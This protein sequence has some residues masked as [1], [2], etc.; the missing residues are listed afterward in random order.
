MQGEPAMRLLDSSSLQRRGL[1]LI[2]ASELWERFAFFGVQGLVFL[3]LRSRIAER[4]GLK[5]FWAGPALERIISGVAPAAQPGQLASVMVGL[6][7]SLIYVAVII[8]GLVTDHGLRAR[9]VVAVGGALSVAGYALMA[10]EPAFLAGMGLVVIGSGGFKGNISNEFAIRAPAGPR[11]DEAF[12]FFFIALH[13]GMLAA[14][15]VCG[16]L[17]QIAGW[18][19]G[20]AA[21][22][23]GMLLSLLIYLAVPPPSRPKAQET[24]LPDTRTGWSRGQMTG[25]AVLLPVFAMGFI[26]SQ[27][28][29]NVYVG[30]AQA[31]V[32]LMLGG[33][34]MPSTWLLAVD[35]ALE[36]AMLAGS[37]LF[38]RAWRR[39]RPEPDALR[40]VAFAGFPIALAF[41]CL[42]LIRQS[43]GA[44]TVALVLGFHAL[45]GLGYA[46]M[47]PAALAFLT[48]CAPPGSRSTVVGLFY[49]QFAVAAIAA[50]LIGRWLDQIGGPAFWTLH[51]A[52]AAGAGI[53]L[54]LMR[55]W[56]LA[57]LDPDARLPGQHRPGPPIEAPAPLAA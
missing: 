6:Y 22:A 15:L 23:S 18:R 12:R 2:A 35:T 4:G 5:G 51:A 53:A 17:G 14:P 24:R 21:A 46:T 20:F 31:N 32:K 39:R 47:L 33:R 55:R 50:G 54:L 34:L 13:C 9:R 1:T 37:V 45:N 40:K 43:H 11:R 52:I 26:G 10:F 36:L 48:R 57:R 41:G 8:G 27:Q 42:A 56:L 25:F 38:W 29:Y 16:T 30:W 7:T 3:F 49:L 19:W 44:P 28:I